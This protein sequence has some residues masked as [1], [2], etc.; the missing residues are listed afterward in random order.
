MRSGPPR[1][2]P[3]LPGVGLQADIGT[4]A[5]DADTGEQI[6]ETRY[7]VPRGSHSDDIV[8]SPDG[9]RIYVT[10]ATWTFIGW[11]I[12]TVAYDTSG[13]QQW[14]A[15]Y[16][17]NAI[18]IGDQDDWDPFIAVAPDGSKV[19]VTGTSSGGST[20]KDLVTLAYGG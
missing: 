4:Q 12:V 17:A 10:G 16:T 2:D 7:S 14:V 9:S 20:S 8:V 18:S 13:L 3:T 1:P 5:L 6:W 11:N 19:Y 15:R